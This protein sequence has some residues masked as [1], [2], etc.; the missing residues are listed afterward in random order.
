MLSGFAQNNQG[1]AQFVS[2]SLAIGGVA[3]AI[4]ALK[5]VFGVVVSLSGLFGSLGGA[6][7]AAEGAI[8]VAAGGM[9]AKF[10]GMF[11]KVG[12]MA[13]LFFKRL[14]IWFTLA[15]IVNAF[16]GG[17]YSLTTNAKVL[18]VALTSQ[19]DRFFT[20]LTEKMRGMRAGLRDAMSWVES[21]LGFNDAA[22]ASAASASRERAAGA[23]S[24]AGFN[25][26]DAK[27]DHRAEKLLGS[28]VPGQEKA[29]DGAF[30]YA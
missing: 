23:A 27:R 19:F 22:K 21:K 25:A 17:G 4:G 9:A 24:A 26:R 8:G 14:F 30:Q 28:R 7:V 13:G 2:I 12:A 18:L 16:V 15:E 1:I 5:K 11:S 29:T 10:M 6:S 3:I 20:Y